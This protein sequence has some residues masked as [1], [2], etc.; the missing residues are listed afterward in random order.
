VL[1]GN[2]A[3]PGIPDTGNPNINTANAVITLIGR[4]PTEIN[5]SSTG[6]L[7]YI[8]AGK[9]VLDN[10]ITLQ[11]HDAND[12]SLVYVNG[13]SASLTM[14]AGAKITGNTASYGGGVYFMGGDFTMS[15]GEIL[16][17][18]ANFGGGVF[19]P[20]GNFT[21]TGGEI[22]GN[23]ATYDSGGVYVI[24]SGSFT[25]SAGLISGN[26][27]GQ[28]GGG[29]YVSSGSSFDMSGGEISGNSAKYYGGGMYVTESDSSF[30]KTGGT[31]YGDTDAIHTPGSN[32]NTATS[33]NTNGH[34]VY[35]WKANNNEYYR[36]ETLGTED[37]IST[38]DPLPVNSGETAGFWTKL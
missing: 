12:S 31:I 20:D 6:S 24:G 8:R 27:S 2:Y 28:F 23:S 29:V 1:A 19:A 33:G 10:N 21:M 30:S 25:M 32:E 26:S 3:M 13:A 34:A 38:D 22:S 35:Y 4:N 5:L 16:G 36:N 11:G 14:K 17:K 15:G 37:D 7:F 9:L 18:S